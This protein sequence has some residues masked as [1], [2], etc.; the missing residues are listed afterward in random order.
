VPDGVLEFR[1]EHG[2]GGSARKASASG[3][4]FVGAPSPNAAKT[5]WSWPITFVR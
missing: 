5:V 4:V 1:K 2:E 3:A